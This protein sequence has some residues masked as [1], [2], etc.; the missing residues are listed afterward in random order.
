MLILTQP[1]IHH[2]L[3]VA[4]SQICLDWQHV[5]VVHASAVYTHLI[6]AMYAELVM[7]E[8]PVGFMEHAERQHS[9]RN[10]KQSVDLEWWCQRLQS[11]SVKPLLATDFVRSGLW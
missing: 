2:E 3:W 9:D 5:L 11:A 1:G 8:L 4:K 6:V 10:K 7:P